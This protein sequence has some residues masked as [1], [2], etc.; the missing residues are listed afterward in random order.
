MRAML[1]LTWRMRWSKL[2]RGSRSWA[3]LTLAGVLVLSLA[4]SLGM[5]ALP[6]TSVLPSAHRC[7]GPTVSR[8]SFGKAFDLFA[9]KRL[10]VFRYTL[11]NCN[12]MTVKVITYGATVQRISVPGRHHHVANVVLGFKTLRDY[13]TEDSPA[14]PAP[15][16][17]YF[18]ETV[19][20]YANRIAH[21]RFRLDG[22]TYTLPVNNGPNSL[23]GGFV[24]FGN[25]VW[26]PAAVHAPGVAGV[27]MKLV[28][29]N[30]DD[31]KNVG[32]QVNGHFCTGYPGKLTVFVTYTLDNNNRLWIRYHATV[33]GKA[34]VINLTNH[35]Y[36]NLAGESS[37][38]T[39][40]QKLLINADAFTPTNAV[41]IPTGVIA[42]VAGT[43]FD[44]TTPHT[45]GARIN[46]DNRQLLISHGYD[47]NWVINKTGPKFAGLD[48]AARAWDGAT[49]RELTVWT[50]EPGVQ[51]YTGNF[52]QGNLVGASG[53]VY[54]QSAGYTF[55]TQHFPNSPNQPNFPSTVLRPSQVFS[56]TTIF[57]FSTF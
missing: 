10:P 29:P 33:A 8:Q 5:R 45:I 56:S 11:A 41:Q 57:A 49:G 55:E 27:T 39:Y 52:L 38:V 40:R 9:H 23:H 21:G 43:P 3:T 28:S 16:G 35:S 14:P 26:A 20:R 24:G 18:G 53:H 34:T 15:G 54:R 7:G 19:G 42:P 51:V 36:F 17:P 37:L 6:E 44:F 2:R 32:C 13:V 4:G 1:A 46:A 31:G 48:L 47:H 30:G 25:H 22:K 12:H 50:D